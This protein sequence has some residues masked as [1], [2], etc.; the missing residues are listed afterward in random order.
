MRLKD[1]Q[2]PREKYILDE[3][4]SNL[5]SKIINQAD[6][7]HAR[8]NN[9]RE[10]IVVEKE[11]RDFADNYIDVLAVIRTILSFDQYARKGD[12]DRPSLMGISRLINSDEPTTIKELEDFKAKVI[13]DNIKMT[14][15]YNNFTSSLNNLKKVGERGYTGGALIKDVLELDKDV[16]GQMKEFYKANAGTSVTSIEKENVP[17]ISETFMEMI[18]ANYFNILNEGKSD[19]KELDNFYMVVEMSVFDSKKSETIPH[20]NVKNVLITRAKSRDSARKIIAKNAKRSLK[21]MNKKLKEK[22]FSCK[23]KKE[24]CFDNGTVY[25]GYDTMKNKNIKSLSGSDAVSTGVYLLG[26]T[27]GHGTIGS[28]PEICPNKYAIHSSKSSLGR[29]LNKQTECKE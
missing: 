12:P 16:R 18:D 19:S 6:Y 17:T 14:A 2:L 29:Y 28:I 5:Y 24:D 25:Q 3:S 26:G 11:I 22:G 1:V 15:T 4:I 21:E 9:G 13:K 8:I 7:I 20:K 27:C 23:F 10:K